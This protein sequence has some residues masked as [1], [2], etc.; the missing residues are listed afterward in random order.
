MNNRYIISTVVIFVLLTAL[1][2][3][4]RSFA[5]DFHFMALEV[6][7]AVMAVLVLASFFIVKKQIS[8]RPQ[9][10]VRGVYGASLLKLM[11]CMFSMLIYIFMNRGQI[12]KGT[13]FAMMGIYMVYTAMETLFLSK[14]AKQK[15][16]TT[17]G[18]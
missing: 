11:V 1:F 8:E 7:N 2:F 3:S 9:A 13:I 5:P 16:G 18:S 15:P 10:F 14:M 17:S 6:G 4:M 12:H